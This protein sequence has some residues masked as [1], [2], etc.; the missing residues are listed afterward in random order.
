MHIPR[1]RK[2]EER[3][4]YEISIDEEARKKRKGKV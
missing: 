2:K 3:N 4:R 1:R